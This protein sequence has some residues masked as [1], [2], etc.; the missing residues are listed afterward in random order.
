M[1]PPQVPTLDVTPEKVS[2]SAIQAVLMPHTIGGMKRLI[3]FL[4]AIP[5]AQAATA[6]SVPDAP[7]PASPAWIRVQNLDR[8]DRIIVTAM[9]GQKADCD[10]AG[11]T[12]DTLFCDSS[13]W[14]RRGS[15]EVERTRIAQI[16]HDDKM[17][18]FHITIAAGTAVGAVIGAAAPGNHTADARLGYGLGGAL[19]GFVAGCLAAAPVTLVPGRLVYRVRRSMSRAGTVTRNFVPGTSAP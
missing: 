13:P 9:D 3:V 12:N 17:R 18:N 16:R 2:C 11:A 10:F 1:G 6:Q 19:V 15:F 5:L 8:G 7:Q 4:L 14:S